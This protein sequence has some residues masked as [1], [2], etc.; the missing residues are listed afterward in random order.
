MTSNVEDLFSASS[1]SERSLTPSK[2]GISETP[3]PDESLKKSK[4][5]AE[6]F[7]ETGYDEN[8]DAK[9]ISPDEIFYFQKKHRR[10]G[11]IDVW[12][13]YDDGGEFYLS[14]EY[15]NNLEHIICH[16]LVIS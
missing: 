12:W 4:S 8:V 10:V 13:L 5:V 6:S 9:D 3:N 2:E 15:V 14:T 7:A 1:S 11:T 16:P